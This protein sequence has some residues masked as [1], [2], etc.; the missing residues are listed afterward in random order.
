MTNTKPNDNKA[1]AMVPT[2]DG[3]K[4]S[5]KTGADARDYS[6][7]WESTFNPAANGKRDG[8]SDLPASAATTSE[9]EQ[10]VLEELAR[11]LAIWRETFMAEFSKIQHQDAS[12][13]KRLEDVR[14]RYEPIRNR[15][16]REPYAPIP[17]IVRNVIFFAVTCFSAVVFALIPNRLGL[18]W[19][20]ALAIG[21]IMG[22]ILAGMTGLCAY[23]LRHRAFEP[24]KPVAYGV[25]AVV[26]LAWV[27]F[28]VGYST[29]SDGAWISSL[30]AF[31][32]ALACVMVGFATYLSDDEEVGYLNAHRQYHAIQESI[33]P[34]AE[35]MWELQSRYYRSMQAVQE[36]AHRAIMEY[37]Q[38]NRA[39]RR[40]DCPAPAFF[41]VPPIAML[42]T[43]DEELPFAPTR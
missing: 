30:C 1:V 40:P 27:L 43:A 38:A 15:V 33:S 11:Q 35:R 41:E 34:V 6:S 24:Q 20:A 23:L 14:A 31:G 7:F 13:K 37:R 12:Q 36:A 3:S 17:V 10:G 28:G 29:P 42:R 18:H 16:N 26:L 4:G 5:S 39:R 9:W 2:S 25:L 32:L 21:A 19:L 22:A 8:S